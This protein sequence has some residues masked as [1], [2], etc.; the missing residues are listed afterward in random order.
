MLV[1]AGTHEAAPFQ[2]ARYE[3]RYSSTARL[4]NS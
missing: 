3:H 4:Q 2:P 1:I